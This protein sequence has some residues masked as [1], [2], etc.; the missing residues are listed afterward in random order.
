MGGFS[1]QWLDLREPIDHAARSEAVL[2]ALGHYFINDDHIAITDI[3]CGTGSTIRALKGALAQ[4]I[5]WHLI[6]HDDALLAEAAKHTANDKVVCTNADLSTSLDAVFEPKPDLVTTS[7]FLDL[8]SEEWLRGF[9]DQIIDQKL[10]F[11]AALTYDGRGG[12]QP[13]STHEKPVLDAFNAHQKTEKGFGPALGPD[14]ADTAIRLFEEAGYVI[15]HDTSDWVAG[16]KH[17]DFQRMLLEGWKNA[18]CEI[19]PSRASDFEAWFVDRCATI[20][21]GDLSVMVGHKDFLA[22]P[23]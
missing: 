5:A 13:V 7:A 15:C 14:A 6:D 16:P 22:V 17:P 2:S 3:G 9:V 21:R 11:Y 19:T 8:V 10:P 4:D 23:A 12:T 1:S 20:E 18:A